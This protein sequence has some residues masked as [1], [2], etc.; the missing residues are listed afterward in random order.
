M[1]KSFLNDTSKPRG[2]RNNNPGNIRFSN[3]NNWK[4]KIPFAQNKDY[5]GSPSN[6]VREF[7][8][9]V[10][11]KS[12][13]RAKMV[14]IYNY[15]NNGHNT[16]DKIITR[17]APPFENNTANYIATVVKMTGIAKHFPIVLTDTV[18][19]A[20]CKAILYV[21]NGSTF[22]GLITDNDFKE[23]LAIFDNPLVKKKI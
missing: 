6:V 12:G 4:G 21:E 7:E 14:I 19:V 1:S 5:S 15:I 23:A 20:L 8:Q 22:S 17:F 11:V 9:F 3:A 13:L 18:L 2:F 10:D 16:I